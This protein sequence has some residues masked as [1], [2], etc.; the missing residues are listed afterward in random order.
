MAWVNGVEV[1]DDELGRSWSASS[2]YDDIPVKLQE[3]WDRVGHE[4]DAG[5]HEAAGHV[6]DV[7]EWGVITVTGAYCPHEERKFSTLP[8]RRC[9]RP[10]G[11]GTVHEGVGLCS[12]HKGNQ[13][14]RSTE[15]AILMAHLYGGEMNVTPWEALLSQVRILA[16]Q[17]RYCQMKIENMERE[18][19]VDAISGAAG[20][21]GS[22][23]YW[24][25]MME[26][27]GERLAKVAKMAIDAG[28]AERLV[29]QVELE[30]DHM[31]IAAMEMMDRLGI[32][33]TQRDEALE[34]MGRRLLE[35]E[36][37]SVAG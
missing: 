9:A 27:R 22:A 28:V 21:S 3:V 17:V 33:G 16:N 29:R 8:A 32:H 24:I 35:L 11:H 18:Y 1:A 14:A 6:L 31:V 2:A 36:Q 15:A 23:A 4:V 20:E 13:K 7:D 37:G 26:A 25:S 12:T 19:G 5:D 30:A 10:A 34:Q